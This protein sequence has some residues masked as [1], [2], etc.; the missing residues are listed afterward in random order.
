M[1]S[2]NSNEYERAIKILEEWAE[3]SSMSEDCG[4]YE[5]L[6]KLMDIC[7]GFKLCTYCSDVKKCD[8]CDVKTCNI[9]E[10]AP[11]GH[12]ITEIE[13][14]DLYVVMKAFLDHIA[15]PNFL[16]QC[17]VYKGLTFLQGL[18]KLN[19]RDL[20]EMLLSNTHGSK[21]RVFAQPVI[22]DYQSVDWLRKEGI[23]LN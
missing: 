17:G 21:C 6:Y 2:N 19:R 15:N 4:G 7:S 16:I 11:F 18:I 13:G 9:T 22:I 8:Y 1:A 23:M 20:V 10:T 3:N 5:L 14:E 12:L